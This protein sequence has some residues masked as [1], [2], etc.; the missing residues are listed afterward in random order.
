MDIL[1]SFTNLM[2]IKNSFSLILFHC[3]P[4]KIDEF[5]FKNGVHFG[6]KKSALIAGKRK[7]YSLKTYKNYKSNILYL[8]QVKIEFNTIEEV[9]DMG[10][11]WFKYKD[12]VMIRDNLD[13]VS[14]KNKYEPDIYKSYY[15]V[16]PSTCN[17]LEVK[18]I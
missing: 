10:D 2:A 3:S 15:V 12:T 6:S 8:Y 5:N 13:V 1:Y 14:Y 17:I 4:Y 11:D 16:N 7:L 18:E 9:F